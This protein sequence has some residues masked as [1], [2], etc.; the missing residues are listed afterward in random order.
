MSAPGR[1]DPQ[2]FDFILRNLTRIGRQMRARRI[3]RLSIRGGS[4]L[5]APT[6]AAAHVPAAAVAGAP[7]A[8]AQSAEEDS[9]PTVLETFLAA[10]MAGVV[11]T[12]VLYPMEIVRTH[13]TV[14][15]AA[16]HAS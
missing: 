5:R 14:A 6:A 15:H 3:Q 16:E 11:S 4:R 13:V 9:D 1:S 2:V 10:G 12:V 7:P 8:S